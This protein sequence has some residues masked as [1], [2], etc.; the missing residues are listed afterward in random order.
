MRS[1]RMLCGLCVAASLA[2][3]TP[4][5]LP[6]EPTLESEYHVAPPD[7]LQITIRPEPVVSQ[8]LTVRP[9]GKI[10]VDLIGEVEVR[11]KTVP[12]IQA[13][14]T[15]RLKEFIVHP[16]VTVTLQA[17]NS[18]RY[19]V[20]GE[21]RRPGAYA[22]IG[23][24]TAVQGLFEAGGP[25]PFAVLSS[26]NLVRPTVGQGQVYRI[27]FTEITSQGLGDTNYLLAPGDIIY[28]PPNTSAKIGYALQV[29]FFPIQQIIGLGSQAARAGAY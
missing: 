7:L 15:Q 17:S 9:D 13:V 6:G 27:N 2:C 28:V 4:P 29:I 22:L 12:E 3:A 16:D 10:S 26:A 19:Y 11:G 20:F 1:W 23:D 25:S 14:V 21:V 5:R 18:R 24:V 8:N